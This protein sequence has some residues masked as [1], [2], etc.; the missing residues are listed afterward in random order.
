ML[1]IMGT[2]DKPTKGEIWICG[3]KIKSTTDDK[4]LASL[5]LNYLA[6]VF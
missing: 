1:N 5:R 3:N 4:L 2:I 6:F